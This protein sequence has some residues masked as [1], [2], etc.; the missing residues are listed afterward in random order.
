MLQN[1]F[2]KSNDH[3]GGISPLIHLGACTWTQHNSKF[4][5]G[6]AGGIST[7]FDLLAAKEKCIEVGVAECSGVTCKSN[8]DCTVRV[9]PDLQTSPSGETTHVHDCG[10]RGERHAGA[11]VPNRAVEAAA[12]QCDFRLGRGVGFIRKEGRGV[13]VEVVCLNQFATNFLN[14]VNLHAIYSDH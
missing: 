5:G 12:R 4:L 1:I 9:G 11:T 8:G 3:L 14:I 7:N 2:T 10:T 6:Y 13:T